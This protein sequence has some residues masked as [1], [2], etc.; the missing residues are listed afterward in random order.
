MALAVRSDAAGPLPSDGFGPRSDWMGDMDSQLRD[1]QVNHVIIPGT[2]D[3]GTYAISEAG[4]FAPDAPM[5]RIATALKEKHVNLTAVQLSL[6]LNSSPSLVKDFVSGWSRTQ[7]RTISEQLSDGIRYLDLR[8]TGNVTAGGDAYIAHGLFGDSLSE[9]IRQVRD[10]TV[11][12]PKEVIVIEI[13][14]FNAMSLDAHHRLINDIENQLGPYLVSRERPDGTLAVHPNITF[15]ELWDSGKRI[16]VIYERDGLV[17][18]HANEL[19][20]DRPAFTTFTGADEDHALWPDAQALDLTW[21]EQTTTDG[22]I[23]F[24]ALDVTSQRNLFPPGATPCVDCPFQGHAAI[25]TETPEMLGASATYGVLGQY[26]DPAYQFVG[27]AINVV[28][29]C[30]VDS[31]FPFVHCSVQ[32][33]PPPP[34]PPEPATIADWEGDAGPNGQSV[35]PNVLGYLEGAWSSGD[36]FND[37]IGTLNIID[38]DRYERIVEPTFGMS[39]VDLLI[40]L[41]RQISLQHTRTPGPDNHTPDLRLGDRVDFTASLGPFTQRALDSSYG[42][43]SSFIGPHIYLQWDFGDGEITCVPTGLFAVTPCQRPEITTTHVYAAPGCYT[44]KA[45]LM[46]FN[47]PRNEGQEV[48]CV[49]P[50][51]AALHVTAPPAI[52]VQPTEPGGGA[53]VGSSLAL[54]AFLGLSTASD[55]FDAAPALA[56]I[57]G[58]IADVA[59]PV[60]LDTIFPSGISPVD[61]FYRDKWG[62]RGIGVSSVNVVAP[63]RITIAGTLTPNV[64]GGRFIELTL[65]NVGLGVADQVVL[66]NVTFRTLIGSGSAQL[67]VVAPPILVGRLEPGASW[68]LRLAVDIPATVKRFSVTEAAAVYDAAGGT[69]VLSGSQSFIR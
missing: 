26:I 63:P 64:A 10:F 59:A 13:S 65:L 35:G 12:H 11:Q 9:M 54:Q 30:T 52:V 8:A 57:E 36:R 42:L 66:T 58:E 31:S 56:S 25:L 50:P 2:H 51:V 45:F 24:L 40:W 67:S 27:Q 32:S 22:L 38:I 5:I 4:L 68:L 6:A 37:A 17:F 47:G 23:H 61:F 19:L 41:N 29:S 34:I 1:L 3:S 28:K 33:A 39:Y 48:V 21:P 20:A 16:F 43:L 14:H 60:T 18:A 46:S 7:I 49:A 69:T 44:V 55:P 53:R 15:G 62:E